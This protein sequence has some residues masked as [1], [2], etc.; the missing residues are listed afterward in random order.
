MR[1]P[2]RGGHFV[3][4]FFLNA[5]LV[6]GARLADA[7]DL[8]YLGN[9]HIPPGFIT[10]H[11]HFLIHL[12]DDHAGAIVTPHVVESALELVVCCRANRAC[13]ESSAESGEI[14]WN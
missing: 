14:D 5:L 3:P 12:N 13:S 10:G 6:F 8:G 2:P 1:S 4:P 9:R 7:F 11:A